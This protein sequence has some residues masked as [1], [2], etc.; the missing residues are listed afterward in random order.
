MALMADAPLPLTLRN[1]DRMKHWK[2]ISALAVLLIAAGTVLGV[3]IGSDRLMGLNRIPDNAL[4]N[5]PTLNL[6][7]T[8]EALTDYL[9]AASLDFSEKE[10]VRV[11]PRLVSGLEYLEQINQESLSTN[12]YPD[13]Y[14]IGNDSL[15]KAWLAGLACPVDDEGFVSA[16]NFPQQAVNAVTCKGKVAGYP[17][18]FETS[19]L[20]YNQTYMED[21]ARSAMEA[22]A[23]A[24]EGQAAMAALE[25]NGEP[26][27]EPVRD[28][29]ETASQAPWEDENQVRERAQAMIPS[30]ID[31]ILAFA[32]SYNAPEQVEAVF[33]WDVSDIFYNYFFAGN[34][35]DVGGV[36]GDDTEKIDIYN[37]DAIK[38]LTAY[39]ELNQFFSIAPDEVD[40]NSVVNEFLEG[41]L[42]FTVATTDVL[43]RLEEAKRNGEFP[44]EYGVT[45]VPD[46]NEE[47]STRS[48]S[49]TST[50]VVNG[51]S[52]K[53][54]MANRFAR[55][56]TGEAAGELFAET[57]K[58]PSCS[59]AEYSVPQEEAFAREYADSV[60]IPK[61]MA[62]SNYWVQMEIAFTRIWEGEEV[63]ATLQALSEQIL[64]QIKGEPVTEEYIEPPEEET[65]T[66]ENTD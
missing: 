38:C 35:I 30:T 24:L 60:P 27:A 11:I 44:Y 65:E 9:A 63:S 7:Y 40:Y 32:D 18:Y 37:M 52:E 23:D 1:G 64:T 2:K 19:A 34:Y 10:D 4:V 59:R 13:L 28:S 58:I 51:Y 15:E 46:I 17:F 20:I 16:D 31:H 21:L 49:V 5:R 45:N 8:D 29:G 14:I 33:K 22:E 61:M 62:A 12:M 43:A 54:E 42:V 26:S 55:Y 66:V 41:K 57:G 25:E 6:W 50:V 36:N 39:Q 56:L 48:L 47:L 3:G 53:K